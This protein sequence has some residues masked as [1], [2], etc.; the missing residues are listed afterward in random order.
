[1]QYLM[2]GLLGKKRKG[3]GVYVPQN[4]RDAWDRAVTTARRISFQTLNYGGR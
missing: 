3:G 1:L 2:L 4:A